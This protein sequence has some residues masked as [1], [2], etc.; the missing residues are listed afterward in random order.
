[1][2]TTREKE[3]LLQACNNCTV[4][5]INKYLKLRKTVDSVEGYVIMVA[6]FIM[7]LAME[8]PMRRRSRSIIIRYGV[9]TGQIKHELYPVWAMFLAMLFGGT[10][11]ISVQKLDQNKQHMKL[12]FDAFLL[13]QHSVPYFLC[14]YYPTIFLLGC[15]TVEQ[16]GAAWL[17]SKP[18]SENGINWLARYMKSEHQLSTSYNPRT[19]QGYK[20]LVL[21]HN[22]S[23]KI[24]E[25]EVT[26]DNIWSPPICRLKDLCLSFTLF[27]LKVRRYFRYNCPECKLDKTRD[28][29]FDGLLQA[30]Q[31]YER[32]FQV[33]EAEL[34]FLYDFFFTKYASIMYGKEVCHHFVETSARDILVTK[35]VLVA[36]LIFQLP[37][38]SSYCLSDWAKVSLVC[39]YVT[40]PSWQ[41]ND[42]IKKLLLLQGRPHK[43]IQY[44][45]NN[46][47]QYSI[48]DS[49]SSSGKAS[50]PIELTM[51]VKMAVARAIKNSRNGLLSN[52]T[53]ALVRVR[54]KCE[55]LH[56]ACMISQ[57]F[58][59]TDSILVWH[60]ATSYCEISETIR[61]PEENDVPRNQV[62][63]SSLSKYCAYLVVFTPTLLPGNP[64]E[65][66]CT[67][68]ELT[69][70]AK[71][72]L[73]GLIS[74]REKYEKLRGLRNVTIETM[75]AQL[76][77][78][79]VM[80]G[81]ALE[82]IGNHK[83][84]W[85]VLADFWVEMLVYI[86]PSDN[87]ASHIELLAESGEFVTHVWALLMH[88]G[89][90]ERPAP[91][92]AAAAV[93]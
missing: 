80:L 74:P 63:A 67:L 32:A 91:A 81:K 48:L 59:T 90:L 76:L 89:I 31:D 4:R 19:M 45:S 41:E 10:S 16:W 75:H 58:T 72:V 50:K 6:V 79:G 21:L 57:E 52:G 87:V 46:L 93:P 13:L 29:V 35:I 12:Y 8:A 88:A 33:I 15:R 66:E 43:W 62:L 92:A 68:Y 27:H 82:S 71:G 61:R 24:G 51:E 38:I 36:L 73:Q 47:G 77:A 9:G 69:K 11:A 18:S 20:Y 22:G 40:H 17:A 65:T 3:M 83:V 56:W 42:F 1:M 78:K 30:E 23:S 44:W 85:D 64:V 60:I 26:L 39:K 34:G 28:L 49:F 37:Q 25:S 2:N 14:I 53:S 54:H 55:E 7:V 84:R 5:W 86:A 70:E